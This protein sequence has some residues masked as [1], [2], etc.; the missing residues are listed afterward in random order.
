M[1]E[2]T[3]HRLRSRS[4]YVQLYYILW[5]RNKKGLTSDSRRYDLLEK[6]VYEIE[7]A[8]N[9]DDAERNSIFHT[10]VTHKENMALEVSQGSRAKMI[11]RLVVKTQLPRNCET[12]LTVVC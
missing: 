4:E 7:A 11:P 6:L 12:K 2:T 3:R 1:R 10:G 8:P 5:W 9:L